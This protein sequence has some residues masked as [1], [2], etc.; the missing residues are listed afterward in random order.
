VAISQSRYFARALTASSTFSAWPARDGAVRKREDG[1]VIIDPEK[2]KG[3][4]QIVDSC[5]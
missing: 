3:Q 5:P 4:K 2:S 1:I